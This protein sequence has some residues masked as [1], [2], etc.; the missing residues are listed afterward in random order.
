MEI[1]RSVAPEKPAQRVQS[2]LLE[3][4]LEN[5]MS[6][7][8]ARIPLRRGLNIIC[9][10]N[11]SGKS[12]ILLAIAVALGQIYTERS[13]K[14][15]DLIRRGKNTARVSL[16][17]DNKP[18]NGKRPI[19]FAR[20]DT[21]MLS[22]YLKSDGSYWYE[23]DYREISKNEVTRL[24]HQ[25]GINPDNLLIIMHQGMIE[26]FSVTS[27]QDKLQMVEE[28]VGFKE[29]RERILGAQQ[30][31]TGLISEESAL[32][33]I[34]ENA[35]QTLDH[36][37]AVYDRFVQKKSLVERKTQLEHEWVWAQV[38]KNEKA[39]R[40]LTEKLGVKARSLDGLMQR[41]ERTK[42]AAAELNTRL[43][44]KQTEWRKLYFSL[45]RLEKEKARAEVGSEKAVQTVTLIETMVQTLEETLADLQGERRQHVQERVASLQHTA[46]TLKREVD[47][48]KRR[49]G[50]LNREIEDIQGEVGR[51]EKETASL[52]EK[53]IDLRINEA[54]LGFQ[55]K[56]LEHEIAELKHSIREVE[57][58]LK[59]LEADEQRA[60]PRIMTDRSPSEIVEEIR[61]T[62][63][64][65]STFSDVPE[66][67]AKI[68]ANYAGTYEELKRKLAVVSE[69]KKLALLE[70]EKR[71][72]VW[73]E[74]LQSLL[75]QVNPVYQEILVPINASGMVRLADPDDIELAG[76]E[77]L[78]G[79]RGAAAV[80]L[81]AY[82]QSGGERSAAVMAFLLSLQQKV[83]SPLRAVDEFDVHLDPRNRE[84]I[85][86]LILSYI[87][88]GSGS[89]YLAI[90]PSQITVADKNVHVVVVQNTYGRS[91][92]KEV[93]PA[94]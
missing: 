89:Q 41:I 15:S 20:T 60:G 17:F 58:E 48:H 7:E 52:T 14:L 39:L 25:F 16:L 3:V 34:I 23:A 70:V 91:T 90:T 22:R 53:Y 19:P 28:A 47:E 9:G 85:F 24:F 83:V 74:A 43:S 54:V 94:A 26:T 12:S 78:V 84:A 42:A 65:L 66:D 63:G 68:Y 55:K 82:T 71:K 87:K 93:Q 2:T 4:I 32:Q 81:D 56:N 62:A 88:D 69:N 29:Y 80:V 35:S 73:K 92:V 40:T 67:A 50:E 31:L 33:Q 49:L 46:E 8:Y 38:I 21:F 6:Y 51:T 61:V 59:R 36:W 10:P 30:T 77:L 57:E 79:F 1:E 64:H 75:N 13:R 37:K 5:F 86:K 27:P 44:S 76:L 18:K 72:G 11:G 45:L